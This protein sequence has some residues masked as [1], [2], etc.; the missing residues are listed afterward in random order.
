MSN[1]SPPN[2]SESTPFAHLDTMIAALAEGT[3]PEDQRLFLR[4][5]VRG[6]ELVVETSGR[7][8]DVGALVDARTPKEARQ[9][10][11]SF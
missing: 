10:A 5:I 9:V 7:T 3:E 8:P 6:L 1:S 4:G 2:A 11:R